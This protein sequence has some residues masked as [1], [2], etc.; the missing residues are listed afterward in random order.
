VGED[1]GIKEHVMK[2]KELIYRLTGMFFAGLVVSVLIVLLELGIEQAAWYLQLSVAVPLGIL[3]T[4]GYFILQWFDLRQERQ[5]LLNR[6]LNINYSE[7]LKP[8]LSK[9][10]NIS[11]EFNSVFQEL[12]L[13]INQREV[14]IKGLD[15]QLKNLSSEESELNERVDALKNISL[16]AIKYLLQESQKSE[17]RSASRD[18]LL[19]ILG[20]VLSTIISI[21]LKH[22]F[23]I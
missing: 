19:L 15:L 7:K 4:S 16:P 23:N 20:A 14:A 22:F 1:A 11:D 17:K 9:L 5:A 6:E 13:A 12:T 2:K 18:Y 3:L 21:P 8:L 10:A